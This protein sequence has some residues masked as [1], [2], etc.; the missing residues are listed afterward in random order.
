[1]SSEDNLRPFGRQIDF[2][3]GRKGTTFMDV[4][5]NIDAMRELVCDHHGLNPE[6]A[7]TFSG[8][9]FVSTCCEGLL[10]RV[11]AMVRERTGG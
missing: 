3:A 2:T 9:G 8:S 1:M 6:I 11:E 4:V 7:T 5:A 10:K